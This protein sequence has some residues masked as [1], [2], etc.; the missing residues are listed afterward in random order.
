MRLALKKRELGE[1]NLDEATYRD[2]PRGPP[3]S[4][5]ATPRIASSRR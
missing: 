3:E 2:A 4:N 5:S 1:P